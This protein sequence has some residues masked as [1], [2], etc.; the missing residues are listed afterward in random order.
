MSPVNSG[1]IINAY[2]VGMDALQAGH[3]VKT[4]L[5]L[6]CGGISGVV[7][8]IVSKIVSALMNASGVSRMIHEAIVAAI[9]STEYTVR[10]GRALGSVSLKN[11]CSECHMK[12]HNI[13]NCPI[14]VYGDRNWARFCHKIGASA[15]DCLHDRLV[16]VVDSNLHD[17]G[18]DGCCIA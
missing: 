7:D 1:S 10:N 14:A 13:R 9:V 17:V 8:L 16:D 4:V 5:H 3:D 6:A 18:S 11:K 12:G 15:N 2:N